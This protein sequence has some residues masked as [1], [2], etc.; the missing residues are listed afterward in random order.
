LKALGVSFQTGR[1]VNRESWSELAGFEAV[2]LA[3]GAGLRAAW[4]FAES[5]PDQ[6]AVLPG[7]KF[8]RSVALGQAP[9]LGAAVLVIGGGN[10]AID[11]ARTAR[12]LG[13]RPTILYRRSREDMPAF[14]SEIEEALAEGVE[15]RCLTSP[16][17]VEAR[18]GGLKM[19]CALNQPGPPDSSGRPR[20][21]K[22]DGSEFT[23]EAQTIISALGES[24]DWSLLPPEAALI[25]QALQVDDLGATSRP[26]LF[27][28]GDAAGQPR[29]V[30]Q[31]IASG[32]KTALAIDAFLTGS[33]DKLKLDK[34][35]R[36]SFG[37]YLS[38][39]PADDSREPV[40]FE[41]LNPASFQP[42]PRLSRPRLDPAQRTGFAQVLAGLS[43]EEASEEAGRCLSC[44]LCH[45][46]D[47]CYLFCP[48]GSVT[49][50]QD[51]QT[52][53]VDY[54]YCKGC[55]ICQHECPVGVIDMEKED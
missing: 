12:R 21:V 39:R 8:L 2:A 33:Q 4:P 43:P 54:D 30:V 53:T 3:H 50:A 52:R 36:A 49:L 1:P 10:T 20:P 41:D 13:S 28:C 7:L 34:A 22:I 18:A 25:G 40:C 9:E 31:A 6:A 44:G 45:Q 17:K 27:C 5:G 14:E 37:R 26:G 16:L 46:C 47:N 35:G 11:A 38:G 23:I 29:S 51:G 48:D 55:G 42:Q 32:K 19:S 24:P 15:L